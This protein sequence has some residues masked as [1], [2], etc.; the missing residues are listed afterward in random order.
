MRMAE[1]VAGSM[2]WL[3]SARRQSR[4]LAAKAMRARVVRK[5]VRM[6]SGVDRLSTAVQVLIKHNRPVHGSIGIESVL[7]NHSHLSPAASAVQLLRAVALLG[8]EG[9]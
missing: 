2:A 9:Q 6:R 7:R 5:A 1:K 4:E 8:I 3:L